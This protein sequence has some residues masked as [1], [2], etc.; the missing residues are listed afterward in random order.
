MRELALSSCAKRPATSEMFSPSSSRFEAAAR[1]LAL[2][3]AI[4]VAL[5][6][7]NS[8]LELLLETSELMS[9]DSSEKLLRA[10]LDQSLS[11]CNCA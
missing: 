2:F 4:L 3:S 11:R 10:F 6:M 9:A 8:R 5:P 1:R 7:E